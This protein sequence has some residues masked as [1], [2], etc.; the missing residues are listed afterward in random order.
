MHIDDAGPRGIADGDPVDVFNDRGVLSLR[1]HVNGTV[2]P[3]VVAAR[4]G[5]NKLSSTGHNVNLLTSQRLNDIGGGP[6]FYS[7]LVE[8]RK[9][10][11]QSHETR[12]QTVS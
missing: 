5:W 7:V 12:S 2:A 9:S 3:G 10:A 11:N 8:V 4:L 6:V 1:A